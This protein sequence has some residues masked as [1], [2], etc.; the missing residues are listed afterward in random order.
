[1][2]FA[3]SSASPLEGERRCGGGRRVK[4]AYASMRPGAAIEQRLAIIET[5]LDRPCGSVMVL[6]PGTEHGDHATRINEE[7]RRHEWNRELRSSLRAARLLYRRGRELLGLGL[8]NGDQEPPLP[9]QI[10]RSSG[11]LNL[12]SAVVPAD[13]QWHPWLDSGS[14]PKIFRDHQ[15]A[16]SI[17]GSLHA[18]FFTIEAATN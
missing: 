9:F 1:M 5:L 2:K 3:V 10:D 8:R 12:N 17:D 16:S 18:P 14:A 6:V 15:P 4:T 7:S 11:G 13:I